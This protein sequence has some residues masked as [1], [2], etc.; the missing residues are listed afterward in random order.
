MFVDIPA[1]WARWIDR[2]DIISVD[3]IGSVNDEGFNGLDLEDVVQY[4]IPR[5]LN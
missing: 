4:G 3:Q 2:L 1:S 5:C